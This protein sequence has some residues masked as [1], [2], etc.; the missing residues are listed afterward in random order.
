[1]LLKSLNG[2]M[3]NIIKGLS[4]AKALGH[5]TLL[6]ELCSKLASVFLDHLLEFYNQILKLK[7]I[8]VAYS[9]NILC[10]ILR[11]KNYYSLNLSLAPCLQKHQS[12][13][14]D[15]DSHLPGRIQNVLFSLM[16]TS[17]DSCQGESLWLMYELSLIIF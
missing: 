9:V 13:R 8:H 4:K 16:K 6:Q 2:E 12:G 1:M 7:S 10:I 5:N 15:S 14:Y 3:L 17:L 11:R